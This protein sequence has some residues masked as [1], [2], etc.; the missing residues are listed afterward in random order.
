MEALQD[1]LRPESDNMQIREDIEKGVYIAGVSM[2]EIET[3]E[4]CFGFLR[5]GDENR[6]VANTNMNATSS[7]S[8]SCLLIYLS[9]RNK[10]TESDYT[11]QSRTVSKTVLNGK[12][13]LVDLAG[14]ERVKKTGAVGKRA[15][16]GIAINLSLSALG[17]VIHA[18]TDAKVTHVPYRDSKLT[19]L[20]QD[21]LGGNCRTSLVVTVGP[22]L[23]NVTETISSL[24]FGRRAMKVA[25]HAKVNADIDYKVLALKLQAQLDIWESDTNKIR[26]ELAKTEAELERI[27]SL[28]PANEAKVE[29]VTQ[30]LVDRDGTIKR[31][32]LEMQALQTAT[33]EALQAV[34]DEHQQEIELLKKAFAAQME[35]AKQE[36][37]AALQAVAEEKDAMLQEIAALKDMQDREITEMKNKYEEEASMLMDELEQ[38]VQATD[39]QK[40]EWETERDQLQSEIEELTDDL[41]KVTTEKETL[42]DEVHKTE[43]SASAE[44][45]FTQIE[46]LEE[47]AEESR[48]EKESL[49]Q[50][51]D[52]LSGQLENVQ[53]DA[54]AELKSLRNELEENEQARTELQIQVQ[55]LKGKER[56]YHQ[57]VHEIIASVGG[58][59]LPEELLDD[60]E[61]SNLGD[62]RSDSV[63]LDIAR[64]DSA[65]L[66]QSDNDSSAEES[67]TAA[68]DVVS[69]PFPSLEGLLHVS[70][71]AHRPWKQR[72]V[73]LA[74]NILSLYK[75]SHTVELG[76]EPL[77]RIDLTGLDADSVRISHDREHAFAIQDL[78][79]EMHT[80][81]FGTIE[82]SECTAWMLSLR[83]SIALAGT[84][85]EKPKPLPKSQRKSRLPKPS[86]KAPVPESATALPQPSAGVPSLRAKMA[87]VKKVVDDRINDLADC[88]ASSY[89][90]NLIA[91]IEMQATKDA[92]TRVLELDVA[93]HLDV[94]GI[95]MDEHVLMKVDSQPNLRNTAVADI[96]D[97]AVATEAPS[98]ELSIEPHA[99]SGEQ[100]P[101]AIV[102]A[103]AE[104]RVSSISDHHKLLTHIA[105]AIPAGTQQIAASPLQWLVPLIAQ[106]YGVSALTD[107]GADDIAFEL[108]ETMVAKGALDA[109]IQAVVTDNAV[110]T[111]D[112]L[113]KL[114]AATKE[115][116]PKRRNCVG[117]HGYDGISVKKKQAVLA[118]RGDMLRQFLDQLHESTVLA[119][120]DGALSSK[121]KQMRANHAA[122]AIA[123]RLM[124][125][126]LCTLATQCRRL[127]RAANV[128]GELLRHTTASLL[129]RSQRQHRLQSQV[130]EQ[131]TELKVKSQML[132]QSLNMSEEA[133]KAMAARVLQRY[134]R[135]RKK[136]KQDRQSRFDIVRNVQR[137]ATQQAQEAAMEMVKQQTEA[138]AQ[139]QAER[140]PD[141][142]VSLL[143][144]QSLKTLDQMFDLFNDFFFDEDSIAFQQYEA[145]K[146]QPS[147]ATLAQL[148][149]QRQLLEDIRIGRGPAFPDF[150]LPTT[151]RARTTT[152]NPLQARMQRR[153][154][155]IPGLIPGRAG[156]S[157]T[158]STVRA[159]R[160]DSQFIAAIT[161]RPVPIPGR[162]MSMQLSSANSS[163]S[164]SPPA[165][166]KT[167]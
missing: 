80:M 68:A 44:E 15:D 94:A 159:G 125:D 165:S 66:E 1:L 163:P 155:L 121:I 104:E 103:P 89:L 128:R 106:S 48:V 161:S 157:D 4:Q 50:R 58:I 22:A 149:R 33:P 84:M 24:L 69:L 167:P 23:Y 47:A 146:H 31:M 74:N 45:L 138:F 139:A 110:V 20:L 64:S 43:L 55:K 136:R 62:S 127:Q 56:A 46:E 108:S 113:N 150:S 101:P 86:R 60:L 53:R 2:F 17:N 115:V 34:R 130:K 82:S 141:P 28:L 67:E 63:Q 18:L 151:T 52:E 148:R 98:E 35:K 111:E 93:D 132:T 70:G 41:E 131:A 120:S 147:E 9:R 57:V 133:R 96:C 166:P 118:Q 73:V 11:D 29:E 49:T 38:Q 30:L 114:T 81:E 144:N 65:E 107:C 87:E 117:L 32:E 160:S 109:L 126:L 164:S 124:V 100:Q 12:L 13:V 129:Q 162:P 72:W 14:S 158:L 27:K 122:S 85:Q 156:R 36:H 25:T 135:Q 152:L 59:D 91:E 88:I 10:M 134:I 26:E 140:G 99:N 3:P 75:S 54:E 21:S 16:E 153:N 119:S 145:G 116:G 143:M 154:S 42:A 123:C 6:A 76:K 77:Q 95:M 40:Q 90:E 137:D 83:D 19:R 8:H 51:I 78:P 71:H 92:L 5:Q 79:G 37:L 61:T 102:D 112:Q 97:S 105:A 7:R 142:T 39:V